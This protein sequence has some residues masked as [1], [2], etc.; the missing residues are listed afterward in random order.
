MKKKLTYT[1]IVNAALSINL[2]NGFEI[3]SVISTNNKVS[4]YLKSNNTNVMIPID[5]L[6]ETE[7]EADAHRLNAEILKYVATLLRN[8][9]LNKYIENY[10]QQV[11]ESFHEFH[12]NLK[13]GDK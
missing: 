1:K 4:F 6:Q 2:E 12:D 3:I 5:E 9:E 7:F 13:V 8:G 10:N 11:I